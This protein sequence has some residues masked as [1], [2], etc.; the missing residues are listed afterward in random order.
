[1]GPDQPF[2]GLQAQGLDRDKVSPLRLEDVAAQYIDEIRP[3]QPR[4]PYYLG[5]W[6]YGGKVAYEMAQQLCAQGEE[7][8]LLAMVQSPGPGY[9]QFRPGTTR[10]HRLV[11]GAIGRL[12]LV[13]DKI[14]EREPHERLRYALNKVRTTTRKKIESLWTRLAWGK[15]GPKDGIIDALT[16]AGKRYR[17][18]P[19]AGRTAIF[20]AG[21][22]PLGVVPDPALGWST[23][24]EGE[25][26]LRE[27]PGYHLGGMEGPRVR[28]LAEQLR[29]CIDG[30]L[31]GR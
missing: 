11:Y 3:V 18:R 25:L 15:A 21:K 10:V 4:G 6:C 2:Y 9:P 13:K 31:T 17:P 8:A 22:Q 23:L 30:A 1:M 26:E 28:I 20:R 19:Y 7:V 27:I 14:L 16:E 24:I 29:D 12:D 5:G